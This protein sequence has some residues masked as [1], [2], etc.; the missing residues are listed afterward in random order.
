M[1]DRDVLCVCRV[2]RLL[3]ARFN[4]V[5]KRER[6]RWKWMDSGWWLANRRVP[7]PLMRSTREKDERLFLV[8]K[9]IGEK[10]ENLSSSNNITGS[11][12]QP[13]TID[14]T[15]S[16]WMASGSK[17]R[18][19]TDQKINHLTNIISRQLYQRLLL[20]ISKYLSEIRYTYEP[21]YLNG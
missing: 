9:V 10:I 2:I 12:K 11:D 7:P 21:D 6:K 17:C 16:E 19:Y 8:S 15:L 20:L 1:R 4:R 13:N 18:T 5:E 3:R 14:V